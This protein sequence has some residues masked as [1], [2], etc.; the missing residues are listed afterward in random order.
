MC[1]IVVSP[2]GSIQVNPV[3]INGN[4]SGDATFNCMAMGGP[5]NMFSWIK[6]RDN[7]VVVSDSELM[8]VNIMASDGGVYQ[9]SVENLAGSDNATV[10]LNGNLDSSDMHAYMLLTIVAL[11][12]FK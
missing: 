11:P 12:L 7:T 9:C 5:E 3:T 10:T 4:D 8:L 1:I 2:E 6:V